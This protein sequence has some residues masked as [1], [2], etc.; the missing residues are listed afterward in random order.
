MG[1]HDDTTRTPC[2]IHR[3][4]TIRSTFTLDRVRSTRIVTRL[5]S[6][7]TSCIVE[8]MRRSARKVMI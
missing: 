7:D 2:K 1:E 3:I 4:K 6:Q 8:Y 5:W